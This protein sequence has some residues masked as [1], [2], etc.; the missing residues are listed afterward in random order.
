MSRKA[1]K[2]VKV[3]WHP[4]IWRIFWQ[5][6]K[7]FDIQ[8]DGSLFLKLEFL[9]QT[10][11]ICY[12]QHSD[13]N[14]SREMEDFLALKNRLLLRRLLI[15]FLFIPFSYADIHIANIRPK[16]NFRKNAT[17][18]WKVDLFP[19]KNLIEKRAFGAKIVT[20]FQATFWRENCHFFQATF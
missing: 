18:G 11:I 16:I 4:S 9:R 3:C 10:T 5:K 8:M 15:F 14:L 13:Q 7:I 2:F 1:T 17:E 12:W 6:V 20:S 19:S